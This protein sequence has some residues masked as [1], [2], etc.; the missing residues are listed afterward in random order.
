MAA[1]FYSVKDSITAK[2][3][4]D[5]LKA[6][7]DEVKNF[8]K[9]NATKFGAGGHGGDDPN[10]K[11]KSGKITEWEAGFNVTNAI[12]VSA[13]GYGIQYFGLETCTLHTTGGNTYNSDC[14]AFNV[15]IVR[16]NLISASRK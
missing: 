2:I 5:C 13:S 11:A 4:P 8:A 14:K 15:V 6:S 9:E 7:A 3:T 12:Q 16:L 10:D 1:L